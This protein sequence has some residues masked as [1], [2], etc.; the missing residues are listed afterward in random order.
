M[1]KRV[2]IRLLSFLG[3]IA[4]SSIGIYFILSNLED[5]IVFFYPP[6][7][8]EKISNAKTKIRVGGLVKDNSIT[9]LG[10]NQIRFTISDYHSDL[11]VEYV[12]LLP[13]LFR[14]KQGIVAEGSFEKGIFL[15]K[16]L[17]AKHDENYMPPE[18]KKILT[19]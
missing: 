2:Q 7:D 17:L 9:V 13:G 11:I 1:K 10:P 12:G 3:V 16:R 6:S 19:K 5:N 4:I 18:V 15:A 14:E 8:I